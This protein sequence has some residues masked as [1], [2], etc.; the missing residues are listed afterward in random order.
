MAYLCG[1]IPFGLILGRVVAQTD[2]RDHGS[3]NIGAT[4]ATRVMGK[5]WGGAVLLLDGL[6]AMIPILIAK[7][8]HVNESIVAAC[9]VLGHIY[10]V[11][12][13]FHGGKGV[14]S[15]LFS[16][17]ALDWRL[18]LLFLVIWGIIFLM[19]RIS[20]LS[21]VVAL[22]VT[23][24]GSLFINHKYSVLIWFLGAIIVYRHKENIKKISEEFRNRTGNNNPN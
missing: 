20:G 6:K 10:P 4:N 23:M 11:W 24:F 12:L 17:L 16:L 19:F 15:I 14:A 7:N 8:Y 13:S 1:S 3:G 9:A 22:T 2:L 5:K 18:G 21:A